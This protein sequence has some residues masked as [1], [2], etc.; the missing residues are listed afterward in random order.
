MISDPGNGSAVLV[1]QNDPHV[2]PGLVSEALDAASLAH[3][4]IRAD[5]GE[6]VPEITDAITAL[7]VLGGTMSV[8]DTDAHPHLGTV[9]QRI[10][11]AVDRGR[12]FLGICLGGQLLA[13]AVG[14]TV[15]LRRHGE[16]GARPIHLTEAGQSDPI[17]AGLDAAVPSFQWHDDAFV[18]PPAALGLA[19]APDCPH[20]AFRVGDRAYGTQ[21][22]P[23]VTAA[24]ARTWCV[25]D[26]VDPAA[27]M[28]GFLQTA[29]AY[30]RASRR[31]LANFF[32]IVREGRRGLIDSG[33]I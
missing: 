20:Q 1:V 22:H 18:P 16:K 31:F 32:G 4:L 21:F 28:P 3:R 24:I 25:N 23:E 12:P 8:Y 33:R 13:K 10:R 15:H 11:D 27:V 29:D 2:P 7:V 26:G 30:E 9:E 14:G 6:P 17:F 19:T 5:R